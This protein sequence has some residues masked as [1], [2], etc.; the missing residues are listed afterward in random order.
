MR[1][2]VALNPNPETVSPNGSK[3]HRLKTPKSLYN[4]STQQLTLQYALVQPKIRVLEKD[5]AK[6]TFS[7]LFL[8][9]G[10][11]EDIELTWLT[12]SSK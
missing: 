4:P 12:D 6:T 1:V 11:Y 3:G 10:S 9:S 5:Q 7:R 8:N 2:A